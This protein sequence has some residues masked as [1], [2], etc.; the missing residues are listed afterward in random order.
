M[1]FGSEQLLLVHLKYPEISTLLSVVCMRSDFISAE[2]QRKVRGYKKR[3][4]AKQIV[5][6][7]TGSRKSFPELSELIARYVA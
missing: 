4:Q 7:W 1:S 6:M 3:Y 2:L 5:D